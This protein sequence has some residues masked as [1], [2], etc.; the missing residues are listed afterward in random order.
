MTQA[1][2][3]AP[4]TPAAAPRAPVRPPVSITDFIT[5]GSLAAACEELTRL[6]GIDV[7]LR[8]AEGRKIV[9]REGATPWGIGGAAPPL[10]DRFEAIPLVVE[11]RAIGSL[12]LG[13]SPDDDPRR[14]H[15]RS[16][17][18]HIAKTA[19]DFCRQDLDLRHRVKE[20]QALYRLS[21]LLVRA[22]KSDTVLDIA[23]ESALDALELD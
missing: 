6:T 16:A 14:A 10:S 11:D 19:S 1:V 17:L 21:S 13:P 8:D 5:D 15:L 12:V 2:P 3:P 23:L 20:V 7:A 9:R 22:S 4:P 18:S